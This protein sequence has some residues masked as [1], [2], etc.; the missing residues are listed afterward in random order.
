MTWYYAF[1]EFSCRI[2]IPACLSTS[3]TPMLNM[4]V[5]LLTVSPSHFVPWIFH[6]K[7]P[8]PAS[9]DT[10][11]YLSVWTQYRTLVYPQFAF[12]AMCKEVDVLLTYS[13]I[14]NLN[15]ILAPNWCKCFHDIPVA[16]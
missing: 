4:L 8:L 1:V 16:A 6:G 5:N 13:M 9:I 2:W 7:Q 15:S 10:C 11:L 3:I 12:P 14:F